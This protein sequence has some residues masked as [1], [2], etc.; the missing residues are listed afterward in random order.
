MVR[1]A[2]VSGGRKGER[3]GHAERRARGGN[4]VEL[5]RESKASRALREG[6]GPVALGRGEG[7]G[8]EGLV[9][10]VQK[11][12]KR[13]CVLL[14]AKV[15]EQPLRRRVGLQQPEEERGRQPRLEVQQQQVDELRIAVRHRTRQRKPLLPHLQQ[16]RHASRRVLLLLEQPRR[17]PPPTDRERLGRQSRVRRPRRRVQLWRQRSEQRLVREGR[18]RASDL[19]LA[20]VVHH[21]HLHLRQAEELAQ[22]R[23][24]QVRVPCEQRA[25]H[26]LRPQ[27]AVLQP[28]Q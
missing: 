11:L 15:D 19:R 1:C 13:L 2:G 8:L 28:R 24:Q 21:R 9:G 23:C 26:P 3:R 4:L 6:L 10:V 5:P 17:Q 12:A 14:P 22:P 7:G 18:G 16:Q 25:H 20:P 27:R